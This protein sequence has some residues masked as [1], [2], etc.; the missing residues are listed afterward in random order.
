MAE[1]KRLHATRIKVLP[2]GSVH[3]QIVSKSTYEGI[4]IEDSKI[5]SSHEDFEEPLEILAGQKIPG[6]KKIH[7]ALKRFFGGLHYRE[8]KIKKN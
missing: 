8:S 5:E 4:I 3:F 6:M 7:Q 1:S 2:K